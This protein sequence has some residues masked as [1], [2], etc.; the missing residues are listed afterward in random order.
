MRVTRDDDAID[1]DSGDRDGGV[2]GEE[3]SDDSEGEGDAFV[4]DGDDLLL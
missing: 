1:T 4:D 3:R 2:A